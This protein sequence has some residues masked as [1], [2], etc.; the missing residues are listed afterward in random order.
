[1]FFEIACDF[2]AAC[3]PE[4]ALF[5]LCGRDAAERIVDWD[6][7]E[8]PSFDEQ[9]QQFQLLV[10]SRRGDYT[11]PEAHRGRI[12]RVELPSN[13]EDISASA[14]REALAQGRPWRRWVAESV[15]Q[16]IE[17]R[18]LYGLKKRS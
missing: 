1:L 3:G 8:G 2:R 17:K 5:L 12:H 6:Y 16:E 7:G 4:V 10:G 14:I 13:L 11:V 18:R 9:L 15:A